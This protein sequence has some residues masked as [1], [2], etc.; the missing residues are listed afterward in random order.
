[1]IL[2]P[3]QKQGKCPEYNVPDAR[4]KNDS[5]CTDGNKTRN[6]LHGRLFN[7]FLTVELLQEREMG[8]YKVEPLLSGTPSGP[9]RQ[10]ARLKGV[11]AQLGLAIAN[12]AGARPN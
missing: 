5:D 6:G 1:M 8:Q 9:R 7:R 3:E 4:C 10:C 12:A 2:T 11:S